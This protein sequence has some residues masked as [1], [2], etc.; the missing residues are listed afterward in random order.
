[1]IKD[2]KSNLLFKVT[3]H[4]SNLGAEWYKKVYQSV[5]YGNE[6]DEKEECVSV[7]KI[8]YFSECLLDT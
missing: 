3:S 4:I 6:K 7:H 2:Y 5:K 1:M 8:V